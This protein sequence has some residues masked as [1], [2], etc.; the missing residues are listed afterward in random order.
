MQVVRGI[1]AYRTA[2]GGFGPST[3]LYA[4]VDAGEYERHQQQQA[5]ALASPLLDAYQRFVESCKARGIE[6]EGDLW[7]D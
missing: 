7:N 6:V 4:D 3:P 5:D 1:I 2:D